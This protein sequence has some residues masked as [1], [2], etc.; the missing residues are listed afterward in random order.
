VRFVTL[1]SDYDGTLASHGRL[2]SD[3][4]RAIERLKETG[5]KVLLVT[6]RHLEDLKQVCQRMD[7]FESVVAE[8]GALLY[9]PSTREEEL[10]A[11]PVDR[12]FVRTLQGRGVPVTTGRGIVA[13]REPHEVTVLEV[14]REFGLELHVIFNKGAV[15][16]LASGVNKETGLARA[17]QGL[18]LS[19]HNTVGIG[20]AENDHAFLNACEFSVAVSNATPALKASA[21]WVTREEN[22]AGVMELITSLIETDLR[23]LARRLGS[24]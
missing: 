20:D 4:I 22:G 18:G 19:F 21:D 13:T 3:T 2:S 14:I 7:L 9:R 23:D 6:G 5:R 15:M 1:A 12:D 10:L 16:V 11:P 8:N 24:G 17:L